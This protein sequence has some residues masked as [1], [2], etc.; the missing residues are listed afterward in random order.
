MSR[1]A[2]PQVLP[3][4]SPQRVAY[5]VRSFSTLCCISGKR[6]NAKNNAFEKTKNQ[7]IVQQ[8]CACERDC[9][10]DIVQRMQRNCAKKAIESVNV[11]HYKKLT[12]VR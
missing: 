9:A 4:V 10:K 8:T 3:Q 5:S 2:A 7:G 11:K 12:P 6:Q 1:A